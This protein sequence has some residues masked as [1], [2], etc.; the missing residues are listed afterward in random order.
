MQKQDS[1]FNPIPKR[2][3]KRKNIQNVFFIQKNSSPYFVFF[4]LKITVNSI[5]VFE[6][7]DFY[8]KVLVKYSKA[9]YHKQ[10]SHYSYN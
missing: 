4:F 6:N 10:V 5:Y 1:Y 2:K 7:L 3:K 9:S 8:D